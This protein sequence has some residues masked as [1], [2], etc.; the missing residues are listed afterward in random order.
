MLNPRLCR[1]VA[2]SIATAFVR[3]SEVIT[4]GRVSAGEWG[5][6]SDVRQ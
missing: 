6:V 3:M 1:Y 5:Q 2:F 4:W